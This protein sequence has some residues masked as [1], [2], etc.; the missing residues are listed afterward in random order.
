M[1]GSERNERDESYLMSFF[2]FQGPTPYTKLCD[3]TLERNDEFCFTYHPSVPGTTLMDIHWG[4]SKS[5][6]IT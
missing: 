2:I 6:Q 3:Y 4:C 5:H 1:N